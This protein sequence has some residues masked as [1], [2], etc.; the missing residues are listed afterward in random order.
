MLDYIVNV[1]LSFLPYLG[2]SIFIIIFAIVLPRIFIRLFNINVE[3]R[4]ISLIERGV[5]AV[6][7]V[8]IALGV[9]F[10]LTSS[11]NTFKLEHHDKVQLNQKIES[12][13]TNREVGEIV[14]RSRKPDMT[15]E[16][17][18]KRFDEITDYRKKDQ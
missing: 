12:Q 16:E 17:R 7:V 10:S 6:V 1:G 5:S 13:N 4:L 9:I 3:K 8:I 14:D 15:Q 18:A 11:A 2:T